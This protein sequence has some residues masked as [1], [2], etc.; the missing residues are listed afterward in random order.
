MP[1]LKKRINVTMDDDLVKLLE[2]LAEKDNVPIATK[3][4]NLLTEI[5]EMHEDQVWEE[6]AEDRLNKKE[7]TISHK[8]AWS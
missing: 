5:M 2:A 1:T 7:K 4:H 6:L 3:A 8:K